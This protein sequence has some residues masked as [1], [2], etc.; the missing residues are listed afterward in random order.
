MKVREKKREIEEMALSLLIK[1]AS[2]ACNMRCRYCFYADEAEHRSKASMG[3]MTAETME[4]ILR[5]VYETDCGICSV[6]FQG[7]EPTLAGLDFFK[8]FTQLALTLP[9]PHRV[10]LQ[11][12]MQ[13]NGL[14]IDEEWARWF[15]ENHVLVG[16]SLDGPK[17][18][19]DRYRVDAEE[20]GTFGR[21][22]NGIELLRRFGVDFNILSVI[23]AEA[24]KNAGRIYSHFTDCGLDYHQFIEC[25][26]PLGEENG[27]AE[28]SLTPKAY[29]GFLKELLDVWHR[30]MMSGH[31]VYN[32]YFENLMMI[33]AGQH[34]ES[35]A[36]QGCCGNH[37]VIEAD[38]SVYPC[39][40][41][42]LDEWRIGDVFRDSWAELERNRRASG[43]IQASFPVPEK[44]RKCRVF[45]L[46]RNGC[47]RLRT[48]AVGSSVPENIYCEAYAEFLPYAVPKLR[49][50]LKMLESRV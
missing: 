50:V 29:A 45:A 3:M 5:R 46:C 35:C 47:R 18:L 8:S 20:Q 17:A 24:A 37:F 30:D 2:G 7:G 10:R 27:A 39:D 36:L 25:L 44:C 12:S 26:D 6:A 22:I 4:Q 14:L 48:A 11:I 28:Y 33:M 16:I 9:N 15:K 49:E 32:R 34:P 31:Y 42:V 19:H 43:F 40:F 41:Y 38:G 23:T 1:P 21:V 13:T